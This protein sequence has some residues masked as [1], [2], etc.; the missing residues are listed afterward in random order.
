MCC[1]ICFRLMVWDFELCAL[2]VL[3]APILELL[4]DSQT[5]LH[6]NDLK[7]PC[8]ML[9]SPVAE[10]DLGEVWPLL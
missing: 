7:H 3:Q 4:G 8:R 1:C 6:R 2:G 5:P 10:G 9:A